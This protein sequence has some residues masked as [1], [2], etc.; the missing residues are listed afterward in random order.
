[1]YARIGAIFVVSG[2]YAVMAVSTDASASAQESS[3]STLNEVKVVYYADL[4]G[5]S[6]PANYGITIL[7]NV[8]VIGSAL[9]ISQSNDD[10]P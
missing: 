5:E 3:G 6:V 8:E 1:M 9:T 10:T 4:I 7:S 2:E